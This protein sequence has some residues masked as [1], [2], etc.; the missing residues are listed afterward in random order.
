M[1]E[2]LNLSISMLETCNLI[3]I[4]LIMLEP[5]LEIPKKFILLDAINFKKLTYLLII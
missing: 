4:D 2:F 3:E 1:E 5:M